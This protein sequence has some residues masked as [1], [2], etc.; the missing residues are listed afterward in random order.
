MSYHL[1][2]LPNFGVLE[3]KLDQKHIDLLY[4]YIKE[5]AYPGYKFEGNTVVA[6]AKDNQWSLIDRD[7]VFE[8]EVLKPA[9]NKYTEQWGWPMNLKS[10]HYHDLTFNRFWTRITTNDQYQSLHDHQGVFSFTIWLKIPTDWKDE[11]EG[12]KAFSHPEATDFVF[13]YTDTM[14]RIQKFNYKLCP[15]MEGTMVVFPSDFNHMVLP[16]WTKPNEYRVA[17]AGDISLNSNFAGEKLAG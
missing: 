17:V 12:D 3:A 11:V 10:T 7:G 5:T 9:V 13:T 14:G 6:H 8:D 1:N 4:S 15:D 2:V 16:G